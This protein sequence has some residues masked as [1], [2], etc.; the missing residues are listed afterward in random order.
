MFDSTMY[1]LSIPLLKLRVTSQSERYG[2][3]VGKFYHAL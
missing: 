3:I 1:V 2:D